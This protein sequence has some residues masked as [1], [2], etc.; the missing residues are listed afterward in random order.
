MPFIPSSD[1]LPW[2]LEDDDH[3]LDCNNDM[4]TVQVLCVN[5]SKFTSDQ[6]AEYTELPEI[7][8]PAVP[9]SDFPPAFTVNNLV[10]V[11]INAVPVDDDVTLTD[12]DQV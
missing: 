4:D 5:T 2:N 12:S 3:L 11:N 7:M 10:M 8:L 1:V 9:A 6:L